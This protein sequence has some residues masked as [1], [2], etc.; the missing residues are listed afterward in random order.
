V[1]QRIAALKARVPA[2]VAL[3]PAP[4]PDLTVRAAGRKK[5]VAALTILVGGAA[6]LGLGIT[7]AVLASSANH[8]LSHPPTGARFDASLEQTMKRDQALT[9][10]FFAI[11]GAALVVS[12]AL[13]VAGRRQQKAMR[14]AV[15][16]G[17]LGVAF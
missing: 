2:P 1:E 12:T 7:F 6:C 14:L 8:D 11:G 16:P 4:A 10:S 3:P 15:S 5:W 13:A 9:A 17:Q